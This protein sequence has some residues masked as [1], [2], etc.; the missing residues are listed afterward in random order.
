MLHFFT[1]KFPYK[2]KTAKIGVLHFL[3]IA[4]SKDKQMISNNNLMLQL[5]SVS[6]NSVFDLG[7]LV[8]VNPW[9]GLKN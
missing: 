5:I 8:R 2:K 1:T 9:R 4:N 6:Q 3:P 7:I